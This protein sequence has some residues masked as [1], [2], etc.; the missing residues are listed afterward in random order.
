MF[1]S[2]VSDFI[3]LMFLSFVTRFIILMFSVFCKSIHN[4]HVSF[5]CKSRHNSHVCC[6]CNSL[7]NSHVSFH[8]FYASEIGVLQCDEAGYIFFRLTGKTSQQLTEESL[9]LLLKLHEGG[10]FAARRKTDFDVVV[11]DGRFHL[12]LSG[13]PNVTMYHIRRGLDM[14]TTFRSIYDFSKQKQRDYIMG[15]MA[16]SPDTKMVLKY[17]MLPLIQRGRMFQPGLKTIMPF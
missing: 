11:N 5:F 9:S 16:D 4:S 1:L 13:Q 7:H 2:F 15:R 8:Y 3:I 17:G 6:F 14:G 12:F 10:S